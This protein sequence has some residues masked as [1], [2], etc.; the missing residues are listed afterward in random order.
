MLN[1][2]TSIEHNLEKHETARVPQDRVLDQP[3]PGV[4]NIDKRSFMRQQ[5]I[6]AVIPTDGLARPLSNDQLQALFPLK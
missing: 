6:N 4:A 5:A 3:P 1:P 2:S